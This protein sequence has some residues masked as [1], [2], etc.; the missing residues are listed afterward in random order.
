MPYLQKDV[1]LAVIEVD[2]SGARAEALNAA[3]LS[4]GI[5]FLMHTTTAFDATVGPSLAPPFDSGC[6][7][8]L[9]KRRLSHLRH[10]DEQIAYQSSLRDG[11]TPERPPSLLGGC[12]SVVSGLLAAET[13]RLV[14]GLEPATTCGGVLRADFRTLQVTRAPLQPIPG[15]AA[16]GERG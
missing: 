12:A 16:C 7:L 13:L 5:P 9:V 11:G 6:H 2:Q 1:D 15:C 4:A 3:C 14:G 10:Y 8:C